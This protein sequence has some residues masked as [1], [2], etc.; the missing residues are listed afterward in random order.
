MHYVTHIYNVITTGKLVVME[1]YDEPTSEHPNGEH[2]TSS[3]F[4][5]GKAAELSLS[6][7]L[8][9]GPDP[10]PVPVEVDLAM[11]G[12]LHDLANCAGFV[13][14][15]QDDV[16][17]SIDVCLSREHYAQS[18]RRR[19]RRDVQPQIDDADVLQ[20]KLTLEQ[21]GECTL[22]DTRWSACCCVLL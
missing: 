22:T 9:D 18:R 8:P 1:A 20:Y 10:D 16:S 19:R 14:V 17:A 5:E 11:L 4:Y 6:R 7:E 2:G 13:Y 3:L 12:R 21:L 15:E